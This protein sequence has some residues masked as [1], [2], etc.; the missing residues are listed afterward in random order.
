MHLLQQSDA[1][2]PK[3]RA[4]L[5]AALNDPL[6]EARLEAL[7]GLA[8]RDP[9]RVLPI[10]AELLQGEWVGSMV[11]QAA[12]WVADPALLPELEAI[13]AEETAEDDPLFVMELGEALDC[14]RRGEPPFERP[15]QLA[16]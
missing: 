6:E 10:V 11:L 14:C 2:T 15:G 4:A 16:G 8:K 13:K 12:S 5:A 9:R 3:A 1:D 7:I